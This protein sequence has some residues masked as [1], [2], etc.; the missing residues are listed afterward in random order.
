LLRENQF[1]YPDMA[2][3]AERLHTRTPERLAFPVQWILHIRIS[4]FII[5]DQ[6]F[7]LFFFSDS[8][9]HLVFCHLLEIRHRKSNPL[10]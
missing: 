9:S 3:H 5:K 8:F 6:F 4:V 2:V 1:F 10:L 7:I